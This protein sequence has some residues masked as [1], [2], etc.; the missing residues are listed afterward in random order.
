MEKIALIPSYEPDDKLIKLVDE[1]VNNNFEIVVVNDGSN[2]SYDKIFNNLKKKSKVIEYKENKGKGHALKEGLIYIKEHYTDYVVITMDSDGQH[3]VKDAIKLCDYALKNPNELVIGKR[4]RS[5]KTPIR[6]RIGNGITR[7]VYHI[8]TGINIYDTQ[9]GLR[10]FTNN[11]MDFLLSVS[12]ERYEYEMNVLLLAPQEK[13]KI[14]EV[15]IETIYIDNNA[16]SHFN[17]L[18]D[19]FR[20]YKEILKFSLSSLISFLID[21]LFY[22]IFVLW[23]Q[24]VTLANIIARIISATTNY[25]INRKIVFKSNRN[26][27]KSFLE[28]FILAG[29]I[30]VLNTILLNSLITIGI[31]AFIAKILAEIVLFIISW[32]VQKKRIFRKED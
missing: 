20:V 32:L 17:T 30:L 14:T 10:C 21:Y 31:N 24:N 19:S 7:L 25:N 11:L 13:I 26:L 16:N 23:F 29:F 6:S 5:S 1:L 28:Y 15:E 27:S 22:T 18:K 8:A 4:I 9:T 2:D 3:T 12:G